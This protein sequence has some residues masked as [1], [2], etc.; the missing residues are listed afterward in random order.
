MVAGHSA[1]FM[2]FARDDVA[3]TGVREDCEPLV[4][5]V[6]GFGQPLCVGFLE[7]LRDRR[8][9]A[10]RG[11]QRKA[12]IAFRVVGREPGRDVRGVIGRRALRNEAH[13][14]GRIVVVVDQLLEQSLCDRTVRR[15]RACRA[16]S[17]DRSPR[18]RTA[19]AT[20]RASPCR[21]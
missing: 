13:A 5:D 19:R 2:S 17:A 10:C 8:Y 3:L 12:G 15:T 20:A 4:V 9:R 7:I 14:V 16:P 21:P 18:S 1:R 11:L 6:P